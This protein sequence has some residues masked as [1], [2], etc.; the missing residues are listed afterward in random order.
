ME[1]R[2]ANT[3]L[4]VRQ[5][6]GGGSGDQIPRADLCICRSGHDLRLSRLGGHTVH[7]PAVSAQHHHLR[8][9]ADVPDAADRVPASGEDD[10]QRGVRGDA[11]DPAQ[12]SVV[13]A[14]NLVILQIPA[15]DRL[16]LTTGEEV[17]RP[18]GDGDTPHSVGVSGQ[19]ELQRARGQVPDLLTTGEESLL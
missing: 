8:L 9:G 12:M 4:M 19:C 17:R 2:T 11:V 7:G 13:I 10:I 5:N 18:S 16:V 1:E 6:R 15:L 14:D 3:L